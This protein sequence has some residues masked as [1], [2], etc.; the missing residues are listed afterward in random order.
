M[1]KFGLVRNQISS[2]HYFPGGQL[3]NSWERIITETTV[4]PNFY[5]LL[6]YAMY[7]FF[8]KKLWKA[9]RSAT[10]SHTRAGA[11][12]LIMRRSLLSLSNPLSSDSL[13]CSIL[14]VAKK[15]LHGFVI[16]DS[17]V[18]LLI[19]CILALW[20]LA[21]SLRYYV[22]DSVGDDSSDDLGKHAS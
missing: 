15:A 22:F 4:G 10:F 13:V 1:P 8:I 6:S 18:S 12:Q 3:Y 19:F 9:S 21:S 16:E 14:Q 17:E 7:I 11:Q 5:V 2:L 20:I